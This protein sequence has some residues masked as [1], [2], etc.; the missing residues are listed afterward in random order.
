MVY[1]QPTNHTQNLREEDID[2]RTY[3]NIVNKIY[4]SY[5]HVQSSVVCTQRS[6]E[7]H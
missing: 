4:Y 7:M 1:V 6:D 3:D 2:I 5:L